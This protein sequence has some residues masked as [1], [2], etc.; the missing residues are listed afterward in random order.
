MTFAKRPLHVPATNI[1]L[2]MPR[3]WWM[4]WWL[5]MVGGVLGC[6]TGWYRLQFNH[7]YLA[8]IRTNFESCLPYAITAPAPKRGKADW[9]AI[10]MCIHETL[11]FLRLQKLFVIHLLHGARHFVKAV[12]L[13]YFS[14]RIEGLNFSSA[15]V[16]STVVMKPGIYE[17]PNFMRSYVT[18]SSNIAIS[19]RWCA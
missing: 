11:I 3:A 18:K 14:Y 8:L 15:S 5:C 19:R 4:M 6:S 1:T 16:H 13:C 12:L 7:C 2:P 10:G 17:N 9:Y